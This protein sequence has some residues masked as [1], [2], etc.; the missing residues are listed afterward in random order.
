MAQLV[1][2]QFWEFTSFSQKA[3]SCLEPA[4]SEL[5]NVVAKSNPVLIHFSGTLAAT[6]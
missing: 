4:V 3:L 2:E 1:L 5:G 6:N